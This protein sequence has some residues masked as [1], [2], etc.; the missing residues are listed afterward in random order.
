MTDTNFR[1]GFISV[2][3]RPNSGKS[4]LINTMIGEKAVITSDKPQTT[5]NNIRCVLN[6]E[7][8][9][10]VFVD[11]PGIHKPKHKLGEKMLAAAERSLNEMD[12]ILLIVDASVAFGKGDKMLAE[13]LS[14]V[15]SPVFLVMNKMDKT[16]FGTAKL[17][18]DRLLEIFLPTQ[19]YYISALAGLNVAELK[20]ELLD[21][22]YEG[23]QYF[24]PDQLVDQPEKF[25]VAELIREKLLKY[26]EQEIPHSIA[27]EITSLKE[28]AE[29]ELVDIDAV[30]YVERSS[31]KRIV[32]G[33][34]GNLLKKVGQ[35]A[36]QEIENLL[37]IQVFLDLW[38]KEQ[39]DWRNKERF[40]KELGY[41]V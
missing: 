30:I 2:I 11:T 25:V 21:Y 39:K 20:R 33:K 40:L 41:E 8:Y 36:R 32:I 26:T 3:G 24:P 10:I 1:S 6:G 16:D 23:P 22:I 37:G 4:T 29:R 27:V 17:K 9:Q 13:K 19:V 12:L 38:V 34:G 7:D 35:E 5:R 28:R 14:K 18:A 31:Q 15:S